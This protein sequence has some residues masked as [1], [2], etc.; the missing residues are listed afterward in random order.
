MTQIQD[1]TRDLFETAKLDGPSE[2]S[3]DAMWASIQ[4]PPRV[5]SRRSPP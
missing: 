1:H 5:A 4:M 2:K 3:R